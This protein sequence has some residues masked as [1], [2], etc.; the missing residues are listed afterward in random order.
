MII[1]IVFCTIL[2]K[3]ILN[4]SV[5]KTLIAMIITFVIM[6][7]GEIISSSI[8]LNKYTMVE[9]RQI[10]YCIL[11]CNLI[12]CIFTIAFITIPIIRQKLYKF[13]YNIKEKG[14]AS[15]FFIFIIS[16]H[17]ISMR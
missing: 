10:W 4:E 9:I 17:R 2:I 14:K 13:V 11:M 5:Y 7:L 6:S 8:F 1:R 16:N 3:F 15:T 12:V